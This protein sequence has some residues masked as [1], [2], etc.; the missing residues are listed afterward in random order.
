MNRRRTALLSLTAL[1]GAALVASPVAPA[2]ADEVEQ[3]KNGTFDTTTAPWW[4]T[5]NVTAYSSDGQ[6]CADIPGG[7]A[8]R[9]DAAVGQNDVTLVKGSRTS[10]PSPRRVRPRGMSCGPS[11]GCKWRP[12]TPGS[13]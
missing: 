10:S 3:L 13:R 2:A 12:T 6:L 4:T 5:S 9:W 8:N 11:S 1:L 7:T